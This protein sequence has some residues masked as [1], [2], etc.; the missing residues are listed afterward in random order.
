MKVNCFVGQ[1]QTISTGDNN[2]SNSNVPSMSLILKSP[3]SLPS[4][5]KDN[6]KREWGV[7]DNFH[8]LCAND[9]WL[10]LGVFSKPQKPLA[11]WHNC[12]A[13][14]VTVHRTAW[15]SAVCGFII[16]KPNKLHRFYILIY[17]FIFNIKYIINS[18]IA[19]IFKKKKKVW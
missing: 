9:K 18:L 17:L 16:R 2:H 10:N 4:K 5:T 15:Y 12:T 19:L 7:N 13:P 8:F 11:K 1:Q 3:P 14:Q 6:C